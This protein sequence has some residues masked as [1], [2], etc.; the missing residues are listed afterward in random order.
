MNTY[1]K[2]LIMLGI[3]CIVG[4]RASVHYI[5]KEGEYF[6]YSRLGL[7]KIQGFNMNKKPD[8]S[9]SIKFDTQEAGDLSETMRNVSELLLKVPH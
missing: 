1:T 9:I 7:Q 4:C 6:S 3:A 8:G 5:S 2:I